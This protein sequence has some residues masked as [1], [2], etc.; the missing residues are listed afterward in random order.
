MDINWV[1]TINSWIK[2]DSSLRGHY[3]LKAPSESCKDRL[4][5]WPGRHF[6]GPPLT[7]WGSQ[8]LGAAA[9][10]GKQAD[11]QAG[12]RRSRVDRDRLLW[13]GRGFPTSLP[14][15]LPTEVTPQN[16]T[17]KAL[18]TCVQ[19]KLPGLETLFSPSLLRVQKLKSEFS[20]VWHQTQGRRSGS[21]HLWERVWAWESKREREKSIDKANAQKQ[22]HWEVGM[23]KMQEF[24]R[25]FPSLPGD[26]YIPT[27]IIFLK[28]RTFIY[29]T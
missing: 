6:H 3:H 8:I 29:V 23:S 27:N 18:D 1:F 5:P 21:K 11:W 17:I 25:T 9:P 12:H 2:S 24:L 26:G 4:N 28:I 19:Q 16:G 22:K 7:E 14:V 15:F 10:R 13:C 20:Q